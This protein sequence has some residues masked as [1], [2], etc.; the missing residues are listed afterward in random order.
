MDS[1]L[2]TKPPS[3]QS[4]KAFVEGKKMHDFTAPTDSVA[5]NSQKITGLATPTA[6]TD[7][8]TKAYSDRPEKLIKIYSKNEVFCT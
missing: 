6:D 1:D 4:V 7:G 5:M 2:A 3:Q 8:S